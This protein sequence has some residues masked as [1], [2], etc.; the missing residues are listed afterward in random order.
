MGQMK[1][2]GMCWNGCALNSFTFK[3]YYLFITW[4]AC[5]NFRHPAKSSVI[6]LSS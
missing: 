2:K 3:T 4:V 5:P 1:E 6:Y